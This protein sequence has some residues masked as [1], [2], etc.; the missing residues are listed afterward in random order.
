[1]SV[2]SMNPPS[3]PRFAMNAGGDD[4]GSRIHVP[5]GGDPELPRALVLFY[6][7]G[8]AYRAQATS[9]TQV[10]SVLESME[11]RGQL[12]PR[13]AVCKVSVKRASSKVRDFF[14]RHFEFN[15][16][17]P[18]FRCEGQSFTGLSELGEVAWQL[19]QDW[20]RLQ[21]Y[22]TEID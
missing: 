8:H 3:P 4:F 9:L 2:A 11:L 20:M 7:M 10:A 13:V 15:G 18:L 6:W 5:H 12:P 1:M 21:G 16:P 14:G 19:T 22:R 17:A